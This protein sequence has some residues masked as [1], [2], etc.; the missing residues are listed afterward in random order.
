MPVFRQTK[1]CLK[2]EAKVAF[3]YYPV[4]LRIARDRVGLTHAYRV[5]FGGAITGQCSRQL[6]S[7]GAEHGFLFHVN[8]RWTD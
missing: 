7:N 6:Y 3:P 2:N 8:W 5:D 4:N 1:V